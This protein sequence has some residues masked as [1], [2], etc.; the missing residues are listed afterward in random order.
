MTGT[1]TAL[2]Q[3]CARCGKEIVAPGVSHWRGD[4]RYCSEVCAVDP[5]EVIS[6]DGYSPTTILNGPNG[7]VIIGP[8]DWMKGL[9]FSWRRGF[10]WDKPEPAKKEMNFAVLD[11]S[12][13][14]GMSPVD[15]RVPDFPLV[16]IRWVDRGGHPVLQFLHVS[17][18][19]GSIRKWVEVPHV[20]PAQEALDP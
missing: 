19:N 5:E 16:P 15:F 2:P 17:G 10:Y 3:H 9:R 13:F 12:K 20:H 4:K 7:P 8:F 14:P 11:M 1:D 6:I 18:F